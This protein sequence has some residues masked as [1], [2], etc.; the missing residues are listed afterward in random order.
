M[1]IG[2]PSCTAFCSWQALNAA[3]EGRDE[4]KVAALKAEAEAH[5][6]FITEIYQMQLDAGRYFLHEHPAGATSWQLE[7]V[8]RILSHGG[9]DRVNGDQ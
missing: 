9:V 3:K 5:M 1:V 6:L 2:S 7:C 8:K 4:A